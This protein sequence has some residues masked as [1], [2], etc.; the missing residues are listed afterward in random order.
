MS[1]QTPAPAVYDCN[2]FAQSLIN[3]RG[4]A[5]A[6]VAAAQAG[7]VIVF[8]RDYVLLEIRELPAKLP[9]RL[10]VTAERVE[11][12]IVDIARYARLVT[13]VPSV[14]TYPRDPDDAHYVDLAIATGSNLIVSRDR[15]LL[16]LMNNANAEGTFLRSR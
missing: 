8:V 13:N 4:P 12:L 14:F 6:C 15:D 5:G 10:S 3:P 1:A 9:A 7:E 2:V 11:H 16:D